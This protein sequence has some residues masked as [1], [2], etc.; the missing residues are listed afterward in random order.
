MARFVS[1]Q[2]RLTTNPQFLFA[3]Q[4]VR[5]VKKDGTTVSIAANDRPEPLNGNSSANEIISNGKIPTRQDTQIETNG[6]V[7]SDEKTT[8]SFA[9]SEDPL[10]Q[11]ES[12]LGSPTAKR[13]EARLAQLLKDS[14]RRSRR[15]S[16]ACDSPGNFDRRVVILVCE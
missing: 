6:S 4:V 14:E 8:A 11:Q 3:N 7:I 1:K 16:F 13:V 9:A 2:T 5:I 10:H 12:E 15:V